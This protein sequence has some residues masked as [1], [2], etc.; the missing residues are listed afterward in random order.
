[1]T[2]SKYL[3]HW[4]CK[5]CVSCHRCQ[6]CVSVQPRQMYVPCD[7]TG[8]DYTGLLQ[9]WHMSP[10]LKLHSPFSLCQS[11]GLLCVCTLHLAT[12]TTAKSDHMQGVPK[13]GVVYKCAST[14]TRIELN[15]TGKESRCENDN[16]PMCVEVQ[17]S[18]DVAKSL[19]HSLTAASLITHLTRQIGVWRARRTE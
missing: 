10:S 4:V 17:C 15:V 16:C 2:D 12:S 3:P 19:Q 9:Q 6:P 14:C 18:Q 1:V 5:G 7:R 8:A 11:V 13:T